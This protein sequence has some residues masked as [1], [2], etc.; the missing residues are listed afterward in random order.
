MS[1][2]AAIIFAAMFI[3]MG[4]LYP[5]VANGSERVT[6]ARSDTADAMLD[7][8]NT[9]IAFVNASYDEPSSTLT[10]TVDNTGTTDLSIEATD[11][12]VNN[13]YT[14]SATT[15]VDGDPSTDLWLPGERLTVEVDVSLTADGSN[16][17]VVVT[18]HGISRSE[19][20]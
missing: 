17:V 1:A 6:D 5:A 15:T 20:V 14:E 2:S 18:N 8:Q 3:A 9:A 12:L 16:R 4:M 19:V 10:V 11:I 13:T 7:Q